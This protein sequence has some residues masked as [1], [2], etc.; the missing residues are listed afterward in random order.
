MEMFIAFVMVAQCIVHVYFC[1]IRAD[2]SIELASRLSTDLSAALDRELRLR[3][4]LDNVR[5]KYGNEAVED[6]E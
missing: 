2:I 6:D 4:T 5:A 3:K 1:G